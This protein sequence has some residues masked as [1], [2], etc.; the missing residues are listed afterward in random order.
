MFNKNKF[1]SISPKDVFV[2]EV[3]LAPLGKTFTLGFFFVRL[4]AI[5]LLP[6]MG[7]L[8]IFR[9]HLKLSAFSKI[10]CS[11]FSDELV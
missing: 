4:Q 2:E 6:P 1:S 5:I 9:L 11:I 8:L 3:N 7:N 10:F